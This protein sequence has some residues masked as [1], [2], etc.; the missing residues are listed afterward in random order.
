VDQ[1]HV[2]APDGPWIMQDFR[3]T[4]WL[5]IRYL[6]AGGNPYE[7]AAYLRWAPADA[8]AFF[9]YTPGIM[10]LLAP[11]AALPWNLAVIVWVVIGLLIVFWIGWESTRLSGLPKRADI[12]CAIV[13]VLLAWLPTQLAFQ[14]GNPSILVVG[15]AVFV[16]G[17]R[18]NDW[19]TAVGLTICLLKVQ[20]GVPIVVLLLSIGLWRP[21]VRAIAMVVLLSLPAG[22]LAVVNS[23]SVSAFLDSLLT[24]LAAQHSSAYGDLTTP[25]AYRWDL[26]GIIGRLTGINFGRALQILL[27]GTVLIIGSWAYARALSTHRKDVALAIGSLTIILCLF[28]NRYDFVLC[29][30]AALTL[31]VSSILL[32]QE[33]ISLR[34]AK[35]TAAA[36]ILGVGFHARH[37][38]QLL[39]IPDDLAQGLNGLAIAA[40]F[41]I[42][43]FLARRRSSGSAVSAEHVNFQHVKVE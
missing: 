38:D 41:M 24:N 4:V 36:L 20:F 29:F 43:L 31:T 40:A 10:T 12:V 35:G 33:P 26:A 39:R 30:P 25:G 27:V 8:S 22:L 42:C 23:G 16:L 6:W 37:I 18:Q 13:S 2:Y 3:D 7:A 5:P 21:V 17:R 32:T 14:T 1:S 11:L 15:A 34:L 19:P 9:L 28:H